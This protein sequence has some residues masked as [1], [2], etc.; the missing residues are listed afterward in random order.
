VKGRE[1]VRERFLL[2]RLIADELRLYGSLLGTRQ[3]YEPSR[4]PKQGSRERNGTRSAGCGSTRIRRWSTSTEVK[5]TT[6]APSLAANSSGLPRSISSG[7][8]PTDRDALLGV[9][10]VRILTINCG[11]LTPKFEPPD[12]PTSTVGSDRMC[13]VLRR[14]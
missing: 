14:R 1:L 2:T 13:N 11:S 6:S 9:Y 7:R 3:P 8:P 12:D 4:W 5:A 10:S